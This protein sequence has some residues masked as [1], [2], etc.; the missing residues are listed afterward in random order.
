MTEKLEDVTAFTLFASEPG[1]L[2]VGIYP[3]EGPVTIVV[4]T[5]MVP[6]DLHEK[7]E[8]SLAKFL[9]CWTDGGTVITSWQ[10]TYEDEQEKLM[11][12][13]LELIESQ[14]DGAARIK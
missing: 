2:S 10:K 9:E 6:D 14:A 7:F 8:E 1:D 11:E 12:E 5:W 3:A 13:A 4:P